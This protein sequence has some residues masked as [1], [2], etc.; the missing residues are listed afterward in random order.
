M[1]DSQ[2]IVTNITK[3]VESLET[4]DFKFIFLV[5]DTKGNPIATVSNIY[6]HALTLKECG[7]NVIMLFEKNDY[8][9][10]DVW[11]DT[12][13]TKDLNHYSI[14]KGDLEVSPQDFF[15]IPEVYGSILKDFLDKNIPSEKVLFVNSFD[16]VS[17]GLD[18]GKSLQDM[19]VNKVITTSNAVSDLIKSFYNIQDPIVVNPMIPEYFGRS[20]KLA[21]PL[22]ALH[23]RDQY[24][25]RRFVK[26]FIEKYPLFKFISFVDMVG[27]P[28][29]IFAKRLSECMVSVWSDELSSFGTFPVESIKCGVP[30]IGK[31]PNIIPEWIDDKNGLWCDTEFSMIGAL[32]RFVKSWLEDSDEFTFTNIDETVEKYNETNFKEQVKLGY[33]S[34]VD[35]RVSEFNKIKEYHTKKLI[36]TNE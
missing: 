13:Y 36:E 15:I 18:I 9:S 24:K 21:K 4:K 12:K 32:G 11:L 35:T 30:V 5:P 27:M 20:G 8:T 19:G 29:E 26:L 17:D 16:Y 7:Y 23:F 1:T 25:K 31:V 10:V 6:R 33:A 14:E 22:I 2:N 3:L 34:L 28:E